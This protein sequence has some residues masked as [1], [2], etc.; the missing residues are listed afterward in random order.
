MLRAFLTSDAFRSW[1]KLLK[2]G[3][4]KKSD[5]TQLLMCLRNYVN[6]ATQHLLVSETGFVLVGPVPGSS[7]GQSSTS[8]RLAL[9]G[10]AVCAAK[11]GSPRLIDAEFAVSQAVGAAKFPT[12]MRA[13]DKVSLPLGDSGAP[14]SALIMPAYAV[15]L[16]EAALALPRGWS[17]ARDI[18]ALNAAVCGAA[19]VAA[20]AAAGYAHV[21]I[22]PGNLMLDGSGLVV[23]IDFGTARR[24]G[25]RFTEGSPYGLDAEGVAGVPYDLTCLGAT[26]WWVQ[27]AGSLP[28]H[29][30]RARL[31]EDLAPA[32]GAA[33]SS[34]PSG[35]PPADV[36]A[37]YCLSP[38]P[39]AP[40]TRLR[41]LLV[42]V[43]AGNEGAAAWRDDPRVIDLD[44]A[45]PAGLA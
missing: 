5:V 40:L 20:F 3:L 21:D 8:V 22:N 32:A 33:P 14:R 39:E 6:T 25:E 27:R 37:E 34:T 45:W 44:H 35:R 7:T 18:L 11:I 10:S 16:S 23:A 2:K 29:C 42:D 38:A 43:L 41:E 17:R 30:T 31:L 13:R 24:V 4:F 15:S 19:A 36:V 9:F 28:P 26:L 12:V 1:R